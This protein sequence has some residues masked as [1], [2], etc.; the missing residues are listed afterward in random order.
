MTIYADLS[1][2]VA[3]AVRG[4]PSGVVRVLRM[5]GEWC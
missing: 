3:R 1:E 2:D 4:V 5:R